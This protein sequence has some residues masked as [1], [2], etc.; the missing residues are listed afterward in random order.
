M[1]RGVVTLSARLRAAIA[2]KP[3]RTAWALTKALSPTPH[4]LAGSVSSLLCRMARAGQ[5]RRR[6]NVRGSWIYRPGK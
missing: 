4:F 6:L 2:A 3:G 1:S 5:V